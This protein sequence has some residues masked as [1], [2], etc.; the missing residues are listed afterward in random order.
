MSRQRYIGL[1]LILLTLLM[2]MLLLASYEHLSNTKLRDL[3]AN[4]NLQNERLPTSLTMDSNSPWA[5]ENTFVN[6]NLIKEQGY[7]FNKKNYHDAFE[8][9]NPTPYRILLFGDSFVWGN[10]DLD[11]ANHIGA[12]VERK[13][14]A[15]TNSNIFQVTSLGQN[16]RSIY[17]YYD[18]FKNKTLTSLKPAVVIYGFYLNDPIPSFTET[19]ICG[20][21]RPEKCKA[22]DPQLNPQYQNCLQGAGNNT[23]KIINRLRT[24]FPLATQTLL[25]R[26]CA[27]QLVKLQAEQFDF[28]RI[29]LQPKKSPYYTTWLRTLRLLKEEL[30]P[31]SIHVANFYLHPNQLP[32]DRV[33][34]KDFLANGYNMIPMRSTYEL[35]KPFES[36]QYVAKEEE[37]FISKV[38]VNPGNAH[39]SSFLSN[40]YVEDITQ[41]ILAHL[42]RKVYDQAAKSASKK[43]EGPL[44]SSTMPS[45]DVIHKNE[46]NQSTVTFDKSIS[47]AYIQRNAAGKELP[48]QYANC[49]N[50][51]YSNF[52]IMLAQGLSGKLRIQ[53]L[54]PKIKTQLGFY[55]YDTE[56][57]R[58]YLPLATKIGPQMVVSIPESKGNPALVIGFPEFGAKCPINKIIDAPNFKI[59]LKNTLY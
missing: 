26:Y 41:Y 53:G 52:Q 48:F 9:D 6:N 7:G 8:N 3:N 57:V 23:S 28:D 46:L 27:P 17:N 51:G 35:Y 10:G 49:L 33:L 42:D 2:P 43:I 25:T 31:Y 54:D 56:H 50:L 30:E 24:P 18:Y 59:T 14:N 15:Q 38:Y 12:Q 58:R 45:F 4:V 5:R 11:T 40:R 37:A 16:G 39:P 47:P 13:L 44:V 34:T 55:Y 21:L 19:I 36:G 22:E 1:F 29:L 20:G 32:A